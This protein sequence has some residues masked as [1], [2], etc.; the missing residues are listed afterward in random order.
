MIPA[1]NAKLVQE[2][3]TSA[4]WPLLKAW[5]QSDLQRVMVALVKADN[6]DEIRILQGRARGYNILL[7]LPEYIATLAKSEKDDGRNG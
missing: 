7:S 6:A 2:M 5:L 4:L 3:K 1:P